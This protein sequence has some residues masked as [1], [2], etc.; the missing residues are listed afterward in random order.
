VGGEEE[1]GCVS[2]A[3]ILKGKYKPKGNFQRDWGQDGTQIKNPSMEG[4]GYFLEQPTVNRH[5]L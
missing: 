1:V 2:K 3:D 5:F 4:F